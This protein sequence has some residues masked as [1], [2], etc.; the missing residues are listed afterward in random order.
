MSLFQPIYLKL[1]KSRFARQ[2]KPI[3]IKKGMVILVSI[4]DEVKDFFRMLSFVG[5]LHH[6]GKVILLAPKKYEPTFQVLKPLLFQPIIYEKKPAVLA[7]E[8]DFL[9]KQLEQWH[10]HSLIELNVP[11]NIHLPYLVNTERRFAF[12]QDKIYPYYNVLIKGNIDT[13]NSFFQ[14]EKDDPKKHF[15]LLKSELRN[16]AKSLPK[17]KPVIF[18]NGEL[19][20]EWNGDKFIWDRTTQAQDMAYRVLSLCDA[21]AGNDDEMAE[22]ARIFGKQIVPQ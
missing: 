10:F 4:P 2:F 16:I 9:K 15:R 12:Y 21:Y 5:D 22:F 14:I 20:T 7:R 11:A 6:V 17:N 3:E 13:F 19:K 1:S 8:F 18:V